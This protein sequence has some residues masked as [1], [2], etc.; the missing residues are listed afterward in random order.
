MFTYL[1]SSFSAVL[2]IS[3]HGFQSLSRAVS[4]QP[5]GFPLVFLVGQVS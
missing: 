2:F 3:S 4:F 1:C 5:E